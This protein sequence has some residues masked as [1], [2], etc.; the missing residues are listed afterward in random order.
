L[1]QVL[2]G[3]QGQ[4]LLNGSRLYELLQP[5]QQP[6]PGVT[7]DPTITF[8]SAAALEG[9]VGGGQVPAG[10][11]GVLYDPEAWAYTPPGE[12][13]DP[14]S[15]AAG[16]AAVAHART[17]RFI[18]APALD[19][20]TVLAP[21]SGSR[22]QAF[23][24]LGLIGRLAAVADVVELQAQSLERDTAAYASFVTAAAAQAAAA[25]PGV[26]VL[27]GLST[28]PP[29]APVTTQN[30][31]ADVRATRSLVNGY[32]LNVPGKGPRCPACQAPRPDIAIQTLRQLG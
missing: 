12:Q 9:A 1:L 13:G 10:T 16:A 17:L 30:L 20:T 23:I 3:S 32:W 26:T 18:V 4:G 31:L 15:A 27:A 29:G 25:H 19:L 11:Y 7:A 8:S 28:N 14:V 24:R 22:W 5:G 21:G 2:A 6:L